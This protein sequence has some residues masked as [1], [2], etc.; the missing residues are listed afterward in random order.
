MGR[1]CLNKPFRES[2]VTGAGAAAV[3]AAAAVEGESLVAWRRACAMTPLN[4][5]WA[6][7]GELAKGRVVE[8]HSWAGGC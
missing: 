4:P 3:A 6:P 8:M 2:N 5:W 1:L 7:R